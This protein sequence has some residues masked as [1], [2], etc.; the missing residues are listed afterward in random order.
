MV[1][2]G[3]K[4]GNELLS[5]FNSLE[6]CELSDVLIP[7]SSILGRTLSKPDTG[8]TGANE[9]ETIITL[10]IMVNIHVIIGVLTRI[11]RA[12]YTRE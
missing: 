5:V 10:G 12:Y 9:E 8:W 2:T 3:K 11:S 7:E 1:V 6:S 4:G